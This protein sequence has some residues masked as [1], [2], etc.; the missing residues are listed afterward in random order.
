MTLRPTSDAPPAVNIAGA[1]RA[2][3]LS[4]D[5]LRVW[6]RRYGFPTPH[7]DTAGE[8]LYTAAQIERL[9]LLKR[10]VDAGE[11]P[12]RL[13]AL[14][15]DE[16]EARLS[17]L[18]Q[19]TALPA[20]GQPAVDKYIDILKSHDVDRL[21]RQLG[22]AREQLGL[23]RFVTD[24]VAPL[25]TRVGDGWMRGQLQVFEEH[26][27][28]ESIQVLLREAI[29]RLP[30]HADAHPRVLLTTFTQE[31]HGLGLLMA[32]ALM[33]LEGARCISLGTGTPIWDIVLAAAAQRADVVALSFSGSMN[34]NQIVDGLAELR[35]KLPA[36]VE[37]W[38]GGAAP[39]LHRRPVPG[40]LPIATIDRVREELTIWRGRASKP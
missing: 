22:R 13:M 37:L 3:G 40:V 9:R 4:K 19:A 34:P 1:E 32:E 35:A 8:R 36:A 29:A 21:R 12:G 31:P 5:T 17:A 38:A 30:A 11:R 7:R 28:T 39:A 10:L 15:A 23:A 20:A 26:L 24:V 27:Y 25:N 2:T 6:E 18:P 14:P 16:L 33:T